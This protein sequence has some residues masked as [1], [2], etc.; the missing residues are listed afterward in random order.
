M[1]K[2]RIKR[3]L[4]FGIILIFVGV[5]IKPAF[6]IDISTIRFSENIKDCNCQAADNFDFVIVKSLLN[7]AEM[8]LNKVDI[9]TDLIAILSKNN[10]EIIE[11]CQENKEICK[12]KLEIINLSY[13][14]GNSSIICSLLENYLYF[15]MDFA[16]DI[17]DIFWKIVLQ[18]PNLEPIYDIFVTLFKN[19]V[20]LEMFV[21]LVIYLI[22]CYEW[23][24]IM[25]THIC[26]RIE[27]LGLQL[28][29]LRNRNAQYY[30]KS[31]FEK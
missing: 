18:F 22:L 4:V 6:A 19:L 26:K 7:R 25:P 15:L 3:G 28:K 13:L 30:D 2:S 12:E 10:P 14:S 11:I 17:P 16:W 9:I 29:Q 27:E 20:R 1:E 24:W 8:L 21:V 23:C 5:V 31:L